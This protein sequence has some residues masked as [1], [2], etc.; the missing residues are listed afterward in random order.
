M[1]NYPDISAV[2]TT[3]LRFYFAPLFLSLSSVSTKQLADLCEELSQHNSDIPVTSTR[4]LVA[5]EKSESLVS[6]ADLLN[7]SRSLLTNEQAYE[8]LLHNHEA[9]L[10]IFRMK[11]K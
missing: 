3:Q 2:I 8:N 7:D 1:D 11:N 4:Q 9:R 6:P 5:M 10:K